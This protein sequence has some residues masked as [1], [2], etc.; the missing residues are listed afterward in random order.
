MAIRNKIRWLSMHIGMGNR[1]THIKEQKRENTESD[2]SRDYK[3]LQ[4]N[5]IANLFIPAIDP[6]W[7]IG[8]SNKQFQE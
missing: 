6:G 5:T 8:Q 7:G 1:R 4:R 3:L 2:V